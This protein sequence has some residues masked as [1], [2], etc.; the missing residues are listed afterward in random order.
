MANKLRAAQNALWALISTTFKDIALTERN[1]S[2]Y[3][4]PAA[5]TDGLAT[6]VAQ[7]DDDAPETLRTMCGPIYDLRAAPTITLALSGKSKDEREVAAFALLDRLQAALESD[8]VLGGA[9]EYADIA[10]AQPCDV[11]KD[12][13]MAGGLHIEVGLLFDAKT[14]AG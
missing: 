13:W 14:P 6:Y 2:G 3:R 1:P 4:T 5:K 12:H 8:R 9:V 11:P 10:S 7:E